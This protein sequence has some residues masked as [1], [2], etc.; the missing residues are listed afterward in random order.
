NGDK[1]RIAGLTIEVASDLRDLSGK[2]RKEQEQDL[3]I[4][5]GDFKRVA[6]KVEEACQR[7]GIPVTAGWIRKARV[8]EDLGWRCPYTGKEFSIGTLL[9][10]VMDKEHIIPHSDRQSDSLDSLVIT[11][12][13]INKWKGKRTAVEFIR[14][15]GG[16]PVPGRPE[17]TIMT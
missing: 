15:F 3:G 12:G 6:A 9:D 5:L 7:R 11:W 13:E 14:D 17:L 1:S 8:A 2:T 16:Q 10:G 4:R